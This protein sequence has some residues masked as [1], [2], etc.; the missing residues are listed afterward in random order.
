RSPPRALRSSESGEAHA[1]APERQAPEVCQSRHS[2]G[3]NFRFQSESM[4]LERTHFG[5][6]RR[7]RRDGQLGRHYG[8]SDRYD[9]RHCLAHWCLEPDSL[10]ATVTQKCAQLVDSPCIGRE[11]QE[12]GSQRATRLLSRLELGEIPPRQTQQALEVTLLNCALQAAESP[13]GPV[14]Q[15]ACI[16]RLESLMKTLGCFLVEP[17]LA[18]L[19]TNR[20][21]H[22]RDL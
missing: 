15:R 21:V 14:V 3:G 10:R 1:T 16:S 18:A 22:G 5:R 12:N 4:L 20:Q 19:R 8:R 13:L 6:N 7:N 2:C 17:F 9:L 11:Q